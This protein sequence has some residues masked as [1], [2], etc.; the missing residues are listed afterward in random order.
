MTQEEYYKLGYL[1][2]ITATITM[3]RQTRTNLTCPYQIQIFAILI[4][5]MEIALNEMVELDSIQK[6]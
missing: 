3:M 2:G 5:N 4:K 1:S 6:M